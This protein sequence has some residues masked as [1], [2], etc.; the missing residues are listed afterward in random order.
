LVVEER[1]AAVRPVDRRPVTNGLIG[2]GARRRIVRAWSVAGVVIGASLYV[3]ALALRW[4][5]IGSPTYGDEGLHYFLAHHLKAVPP[6]TDVFGQTWFHPSWIIEQRPLFYYGFHAIAREGF[7]ALRIANILVTAGLAPVAYALLRSH[8][9]RRPA[10]AMGGAACA[11]V[12]TLAAW[13]AIV[14]MDSMM[15]VLFL[16]ALWARRLGRPYASAA[17]FL[18]AIWMKETAL[19][20]V[21]G[22]LAATWIH[23]WVR[24][25]IPLWPIR[26]DRGQSAL[27]VVLAVG[28]LPIVYAMGNGL[29]L[30]GGP[31]VG[32]T[33][34]LVDALFWSAWLVP[35]LALGLRWRQSRV[36]VGWALAAGLFHLALH[37]VLHR[38][39]EAWYTV[40]PVALSLVGA[41]ASV[42]ALLQAV[43]WRRSW[44]AVSAR[45]V[46]AAAV[47]FLLVALLVPAGGAKE[48]LM[49]PL[50]RQT[51]PSVEDSLRF[52]TLHRDADLRAALGWIEARSI[53]RLVLFDVEYALVLHPFT[54]AVSRPLIAT[55]LLHPVIPQP[56]EASVAA[57]EAN[58]T[59][60]LLQLRPNGFNEAVRAAYAGCQA[61]A[62]GRFVLLQT[63]GCPGQAE[64]LMEAAPYPSAD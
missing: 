18:A 28:L 36:L 7:A 61:E 20:G 11:A 50:S 19:V 3:A 8:G 54:E 6:A 13:G 33:L 58:G 27:L 21:A 31:A 14:L 2:D 52:E 5:Y 46:A 41:T 53:D 40:L 25:G 45:G 62:M 42:D 49:Q 51:F 29:R 47:V 57:M 17:L 34:R 59:W 23:G 9:V 37:G 16:A 22:L 35:L 39:V 24:H 12:P 43:P 38:S 26:L 48:P 64:A 44:P 1:Q 60:T 15:A 63:S 30:P 55:S 56:I 4:Q 32:S 10:A